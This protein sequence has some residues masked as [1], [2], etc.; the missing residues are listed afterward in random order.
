[1]P[2]G[3]TTTLSPSATIDNQGENVGG[4]CGFINLAPRATG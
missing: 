1:M 2:A 4:R 3:A